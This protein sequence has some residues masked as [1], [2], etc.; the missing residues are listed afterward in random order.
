MNKNKKIQLAA[1]IIFGIGTIAHAIRLIYGSPLVIGSWRAP[2]WLSFLAVLL[3]GYLSVMLW[4][5]SNKK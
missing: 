2:M 1:S 4:K 3:A 5:I